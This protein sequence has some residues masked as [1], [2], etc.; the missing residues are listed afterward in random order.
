M[1]A[2]G[3]GIAGN[4]KVVAGGCCCFLVLGLVCLFMSLGSLQP[5]EYGLRYNRFNK[6]IDESYTY[7]GGRH[8]IGPFKT[9]LVF[10][11]TVQN[12][13]FSNRKGHATAPPLETRTGGQAG[14]KLN[15]HIA[16]QYHLARDQLP[17]LYKLANINYE[18]IFLK[19]ARDTLLKAAAE[20]T[21]Q[22]YWEERPAI[23]AEMFKRV[24]TA[25]M[26]SHATCTGLQIMIIELPD[27]YEQSIVTTQVQ[28]QGVKTKRNQQQAALIRAQIGVLIADYQ[29]NITVTLSTATAN[30]A[31]T[32]QSASARASKNKIDA[33]NYALGDVTDN[34]HLSAAGMVEYQRNFAYT[35]KPNASFL[36]GVT[37][38]VTVLGGN[39]GAS[40]QPAP[41]PP[42]ACASAAK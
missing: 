15:L 31:L 23:G 16:F 14:L 24:N 36:F 32:V 39:S 4:P 27:Q 38:A 37:S 30:A 21:A 10:P 1:R 17:A 9:F 8:I 40:Q 11:A 33:E 35:T 34:L 6:V 19:I 3:Q 18:S 5:T 13:E 20:Y 26:T 25:L 41:A 29:N 2:L 28:K 22:E 42:P 12:L 7:H